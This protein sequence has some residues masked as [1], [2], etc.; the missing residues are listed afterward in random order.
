MSVIQSFPVVA[1]ELWGAYQ[2]ALANYKHELFDKDWRHH[3]LIQGFKRK[4][5]EAATAANNKKTMNKSAAQMEGEA[6]LLA[7]SLLGASMEEGL[8]R[9]I[10]QQN[11]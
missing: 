1:D 6:D 7:K 10:N 3:T 5:I 11:Y 2:S 9:V 4:R 8:L